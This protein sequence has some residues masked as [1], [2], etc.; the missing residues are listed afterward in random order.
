MKIG[1]ILTMLENLLK[2]LENQINSNY[3]EFNSEDT[4]C[5]N[6]LKMYSKNFMKIDCILTK[7]EISLKIKKI[8]FNSNYREF[9]SEDMSCQNVLKFH[10]TNLCICLYVV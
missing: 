3:R 10:V 7:L 2:N 5:Q 1:C 9:N 6:D 4:G 8:E